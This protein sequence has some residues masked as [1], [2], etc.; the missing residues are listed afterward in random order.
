MTR[1]DRAYGFIRSITNRLKG[2]E[3][4][5]RDTEKLDLLR[6]KD[7]SRPKGVGKKMESNR[8]ELE[9]RSK[10]P[11]SNNP[12]KSRLQ[13]L[14]KKQLELDKINSVL[15]NNGYSFSR[16]EEKDMEKKVEILEREISKLKLS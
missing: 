3:S 9:R 12:N 5:I 13:K 1:E 2:T 4:I 7:H 15:Y 14:A 8:K 10:L 11:E 6:A 16:K